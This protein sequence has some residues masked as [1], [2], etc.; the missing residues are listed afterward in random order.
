MKL[1]LAI[2]LI[3]GIGTCVFWSF[4]PRATE[5]D[6]YPGTIYPDL[7][8]NQFLNDRGL[9]TLRFIEVIQT[10]PNVQP[11]E[12]LFLLRNDSKE[13]LRSWAN[14]ETSDGRYR[15]FGSAL[16]YVSQV[17]SFSVRG[18]ATGEIDNAPILFTL[19][20]GEEVYLEVSIDSSWIELHPTDKIQIEIMNIVS[21]PFSTHQIAPIERQ[22][23]GEHA[24]TLKP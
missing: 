16:T 18:T 10:E 14:Y 11:K 21:E 22:I 17:G 15:L 4:F 20:P 5:S 8:K 2:C 23:D 7:I 3:L 6:L 24:E 13:S 19:E 9:V 1:G 12:A